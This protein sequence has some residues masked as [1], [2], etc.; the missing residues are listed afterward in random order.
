MLVNTE[1]DVG[2]MSMYTEIGGPD[3]NKEEVG[4]NAAAMKRSSGLSSF[5]TGADSID[6]FPCFERRMRI[7]SK[8]RL[9]AETARQL[10][11][12]PYGVGSCPCL[13][14]L[15]RNDLRANEGRAPM[16]RKK[17]GL[18]QPKSTCPRC[19]RGADVVIF[20]RSYEMCSIGQGATPLDRIEGKR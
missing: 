2:S 8:I 18:W 12:V 3:V 17:N 15:H 5:G 20:Y 7:W 19:T 11:S 16:A 6:N 1:G 4:F 13:S 14:E 10:R 9:I